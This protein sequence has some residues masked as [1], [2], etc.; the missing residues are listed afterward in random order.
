MN[1]VM[2]LLLMEDGNL[3]MHLRDDKA[4]VL[5]PGCWA[6]FGGSIEASETPEDALRREVFEET[7]LQVQR[8]EFLGEFIDEP[9]EG[10]RGDVIGMY[11]CRGSMTPEEIVLTEGAGFGVFSLAQ[12]EAIKLSPFVRRT[13]IAHRD[14]LTTS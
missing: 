13:L 4:G 3:L 2:A 11:L 14:T 1:A 12:L 10:G 9:S 8:A 5:H 7:G 6:G